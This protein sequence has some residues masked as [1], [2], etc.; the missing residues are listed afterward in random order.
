MR[1]S[2]ALPRVGPDAYS[3]A[4]HLLLALATAASMALA[5]L[6]AFA[7]GARLVCLGRALPGVSAAGIGVAG[8]SQAEIES[9]LA[10][11][12]TYPESG[13]LVFQDGD[14]LWAA[15][16]AEIG[17]RI[18]VSAMAHQAL[19]VG[20]RGS[21]L[22]RLEEQVQ[23]WTQGIEIPPVVLFDQ[24]LG[25]AYLERLAA[26]IDQPTVEAEIL[27]RGVEVEVRQGQIGR[28]LDIDATLEALIPVISRLYDARVPLVIEET[29]PLV[30]DAGQQADLARQMLSQPLVLTAEGAGPWSIEPERLATMLRFEVVEGEAGSAYR[31]G[32]DA[33]QMEQFLEPLAPI[34]AREPENARFIFNDDTRQLDLLRPA[35]IGRRLDIPATIQAIT[36]GLNAGQ[37]EIAMAFQT[38]APAVGDQATAEDLGIREN[39]VAVST[40]FAGSSPARIHNIA[41]A[42]AAFHGLLVAPGETLSMAEVLGDISLDTGYQE[43]LIIYGSR[44]INGVGGG[45]CQVST[46]LFRAAFF[47]GYQIDERHPH[48]YRVGYYEQRCNLGATCAG[49]DATVFAPLV[50]FRFTNDTPYWLLLETYVYGTQLLWKFYSTSDGRTVEWTTT[51]LRNVVEA[52]EPLYRENPDLARGEIKQVDYEADG[53]EV[54]VTRTVRRGGEVIHQNTF[55]TRYLPW[56]AIFE[57]GPGTDLPPGAKTE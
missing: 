48:A 39:V 44:T 50:D 36:D 53:A 16:P 57:Y 43:A 40:Y 14:R 41:T 29:P 15:R 23:A 46:T 37:H 54:T 56:R 21:L 28:R 38:T 24:R 9:M 5:G 7:L 34:L 17:V 33:E 52:P 45:V 51:G 27:L 30:L 19:S 26:H 8:R 31:L 20:R 13:L 55:Y 35:V 25:E 18:D 42:A 12:L 11:A 2:R 10:Q 49:L 3:L 1:A 4:R 32:V 6:G 22:E 47:G